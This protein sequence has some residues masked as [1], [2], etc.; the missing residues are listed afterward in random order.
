[1][2][3]KSTLF[4]IFFLL[5]GVATSQLIHPKVHMNVAIGDTMLM[6]QTVF[7]EYVSEGTLAIFKFDSMYI[8]HDDESFLVTAEYNS[9]SMY[10]APLKVGTFTDTIRVRIEYFSKE[11]LGTV[12]REH[13]FP[14]SIEVE[15]SSVV[16]NTE[17]KFLVLELIGNIISLSNPSEKF[18]SME[19]VD[20]LGRYVAASDQTTLDLQNVPHGSYLILIRLKDGVVVKKIFIK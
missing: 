10:A 20:L 9:I 17:D 7:D 6:K 13:Y 3:V 5:P 15:A 12:E 11:I 1:M 16:E 8:K 19:A 4:L 2:R 14:V 18:V